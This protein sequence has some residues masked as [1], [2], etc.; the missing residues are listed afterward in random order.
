MFFGVGSRSKW[1]EKSG[2]CRVPEVEDLEVG[3]GLFMGSV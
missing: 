3:G 2:K 1:V